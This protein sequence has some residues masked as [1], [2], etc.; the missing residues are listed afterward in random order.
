MAQS[1]SYIQVSLFVQGESKDRDYRFWLLPASETLGNTDGKTVRVWRSP[2]GGYFVRSQQKDKPDQFYSSKVRQGYRLYR[3]TSD[4]DDYAEALYK[5]GALT[6]A[7]YEYHK[8]ESRK[9]RDEDYRIEQRDAFNAKMALMGIT[10]N[11]KQQAK[12]LKYF[13]SLKSPF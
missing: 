3:Q 1:R 12:A 10:L 6:K 8:S 5:L 2:D 7:E 9:V 4:S 11:Q 13:D